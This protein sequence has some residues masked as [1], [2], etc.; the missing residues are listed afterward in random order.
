[1]FISKSGTK[2]EFSS[3]TVSYIDFTEKPSEPTVTSGDYV[4][5]G[6]S[7]KWATCNIGATTPTEYGNY[8]SWEETI[9]QRKYIHK[10]N[11]RLLQYIDRHLYINRRRHIAH[12]I[13]RSNR[14]SQSRLE[15]ANQ[16]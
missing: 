13:R 14:K 2:V 12:I 8:Y 7:V 15:N 16:S 5:L 9:N 10:S 11:I 3:E 6:L 4:D 1:M